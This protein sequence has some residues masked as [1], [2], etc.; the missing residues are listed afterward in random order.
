MKIA[1]N[2]F[3]NNSRPFLVMDDRLSWRIGSLHGVM[4]ERITIGD[5]MG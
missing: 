5:I 4:S 2:M 3:F 1:K